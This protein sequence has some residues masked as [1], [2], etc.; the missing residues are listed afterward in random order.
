MELSIEVLM[1]AE[2]KMDKCVEF[3]HHDLSGLR[4]GKASPSLVENITVEYYGTATRLRDIANI[5]TPEPRLL[6]ISPFDPSSLGAIEKGISA[7]NIG[8]TPMNDGRLIRVPIPELS[9][10]RRKDLAKVASRATEEQRIA[11][12]NVRRDANELLKTL[13]KNGKITED[14]RDQSLEEVQKLTD[15]HIKKMDSMLAA[16]EKEV[17]SV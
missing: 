2:E 1:A 8:I 9:E 5:S 11:V 4:T 7:A 14:D 17:L 6:V 3:L 13:Q 15:N 16:K 12:R 10:E